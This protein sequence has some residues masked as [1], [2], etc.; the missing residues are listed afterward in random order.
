MYGEIRLVAAWRQPEGGACLE[1]VFA[2]R[3]MPYVSREL[4]IGLAQVRHVLFRQ[5]NE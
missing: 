2:A 3:E 5:S 1:D 4:P